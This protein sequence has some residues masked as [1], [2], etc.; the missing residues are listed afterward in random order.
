MC[1]SKKSDD[2]SCNQELKKHAEYDNIFYW[3]ERVMQLE[4]ALDANLQRERALEEGAKNLQSNTLVEEFS[5]MLKRAD[6]FLHL[7]LQSTQI[8]IT[9]QVS[10]I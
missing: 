4:K 5:G 3:K 7:V 1:P 9:H 8:V 10:L 6:Y 2:L